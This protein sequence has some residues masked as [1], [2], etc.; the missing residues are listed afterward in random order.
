MFGLETRNVLI[1]LVTVYLAFGLA[2]TAIV[3][4]VAAWLDVRSGTLEAALKEFLAGDL[5]DNEAFVK[6]FYEHPLVQALSKGEDGRPSYIPPAIVGQVVEAL[7][8]AKRATASLAE[9]VNSLPGTPETNRTKWILSAFVTQAGGD[10]A[11]FRQAVAGQFD[12]VM[13][14]ATGATPRETKNKK[15]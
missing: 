10:A 8:V 5:K 6:A 3:E 11:T 14:R 15:K 1:G 4:A 7:V 12:A 13:D 9:A 2:C